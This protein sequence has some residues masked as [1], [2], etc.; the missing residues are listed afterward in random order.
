MGML[1]NYIKIDEPTLAQLTKLS[2][3]DVFEAIEELEENGND[4]YDMDKLWDGLH[5]LITGVPAN[6]RIEGDHLSEAIFGV[7]YFRT[8]DFITYIKSDE[9]GAI[10]E[11]METIP[12][13]DLL[14]EMDLKIFRDKDIYPEIWVDKNRPDLQEDLKTEFDGLLE[15]YKEALN[16]TAHIIV[17]I[18]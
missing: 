12:I 8:E 17:S 15:F 6:D 7:H 9:L 13:D 11:S 2:D 4:V 16:E 14:K 18:Y 3:D 5:F 1:A 10:I